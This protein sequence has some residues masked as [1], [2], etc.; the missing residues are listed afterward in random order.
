MILHFSHIGLTDALTFIGDPH[1]ERAAVLCA[2]ALRLQA[3]FGGRY[4][5]RYVIL[6]LL[7]SYGESSTLTL[8]PGRMRM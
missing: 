5:N 4:L 8:S 1:L 2:A 7:R 6:P 3:T